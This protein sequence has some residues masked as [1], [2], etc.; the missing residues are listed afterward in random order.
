MIN[1]NIIFIVQIIIKTNILGRAKWTNR[2]RDVNTPLAT[3]LP[4]GQ[5]NA[6]PANAN[7][8]NGSGYGGGSSYGNNFTNYN[9]AATNYSNGGTFGNGPN[10][11][12]KGYNN[13]Y[14]NGAYQTGTNNIPRNVPKFQN[15]QYQTQQ[16]NGSAGQK[17]GQNQVYYKL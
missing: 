4:Y 15:P 13:E 1:F 6:R 2:Y 10:Y 8:A 11:Q 5:T 3:Q 16:Y 12:N 14:K 7:Y 9:N 17:Y